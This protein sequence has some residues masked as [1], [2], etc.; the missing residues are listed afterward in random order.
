LFT[1]VI[2][3]FLYTLFGLYLTI[4]ALMANRRK[5]RMGILALV[6]ETFEKERV[7][8]KVNK[9]EK[10]FGEWHRRDGK[11]V[12]ASSDLGGTYRGMST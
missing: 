6:V 12:F 3:C 2:F 10:L 7:P 4:I 5:D 1:V 11:H 9:V 8:E